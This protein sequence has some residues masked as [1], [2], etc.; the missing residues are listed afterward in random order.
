MPKKWQL[1]EDNDA[2]TFHGRRNKGSG[3][4][5]Y[6]PGDS[7]NNTFLV[8]SKLTEK[9]SYSLSW[10]ILD[11][12]EEEALFSYRIPLLSVKINPPKKEPKEVV[13]IFK[14]DWLKILKD[15]AHGE[16]L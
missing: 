4:R 1:K 8:E 12:L 9:G 11:K 15:S 7:K 6:L 5:W 14:D 10:K 16:D 13:V 2:K 3:N